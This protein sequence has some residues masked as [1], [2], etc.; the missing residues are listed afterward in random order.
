YTIRPFNDYDL[1]TNAHE[2]RFR[3]R[4]NRRLSSLRIFVEHAFGRLK[5][6]FPVL[7][8][9]PGNDIDMIYRTV[10]ALMV[11][12]NILE[13]FN[14]DPTDIEEYNGEE[15][16]DADE[17]RGEAAAQLH[18]DD[19]VSEDLLYATGVYRRKWILDLMRGELV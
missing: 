12:H 15:D 18:V 1:T 10:E 8:C 5:G 3:R 19:D 14:D 11:I 2:A 9:M 7:R 17:V 16:D 13:R 6:R 4:F